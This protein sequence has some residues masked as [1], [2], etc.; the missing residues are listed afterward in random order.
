MKTA[1]D[2]VMAVFEL[3]EATEGLPP[4]EGSN[5]H[6]IGFL[7]GRQFE[8]KQIR[9]GIGTL[10]WD[11]G[12][13]GRAPASATASVGREFD[14][15]QCDHCN[16]DGWTWQ[17]RQVAERA[18]DVQEFK[19]ECAECSATG[20]QGPDADKAITASGLID[21]L[22]SA[23]A[24]WNECPGDNTT[25]ERY[26]NAH[27]ALFD[28]LTQPQKRDE[29]DQWVLDRAADLLGEYADESAPRLEEVDYVVSE[30]RRLA[31]A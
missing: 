20:W 22:Q 11:E 2:V 26:R 24:E 27:A 15:W 1:R 4:V 21:R 30:L 12:I 28:A 10:A 31:A 17:P 16:G 6:G 29:D 14:A 19:I 7:K 8:A 23:H 3:C 25:R 9:R 5:E 13:T 18:T